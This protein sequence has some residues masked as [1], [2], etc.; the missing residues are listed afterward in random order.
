L[1][2]QTQDQIEQNLK[3]AKNK[4]IFSSLLNFLVYGLIVFLAS[5]LILYLMDNF[6]KSN[7]SLT[8]SGTILTITITLGI[9]TYI[10]NYKFVNM[11]LEAQT[12]MEK[13]NSAISNQ[14]T[15][16]EGISLATQKE[17]SEMRV[18]IK[19][20]ESKVSVLPVIQ[21]RLDNLK[22]TVDKIEQK[23]NP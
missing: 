13:Q 4:A 6:Q 20:I 19:D 7:P 16:I 1:T 5:S 9:F 17:V 11:N 18:E 12:T 2:N 10:N 15:R 21:E 8:T 23:V 22:K 3:I 14:L